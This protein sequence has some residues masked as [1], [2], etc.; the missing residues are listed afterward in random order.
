MLL[1]GSTP[2]G[3]GPW[4]Q[5]K[6]EF[7]QTIYGVLKIPNRGRDSV[8]RETQLAG[9][10]AEPV[11]IDTVE[12]VLGVNAG[13]RHYLGVLPVEGISALEFEIDRD[14]ERP[15]LGFIDTVGGETV[16]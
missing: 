5:Y 11:V 2:L 14:V 8:S 12:A 16:P 13:A 15:H 9:G 3:F 1:R 6:S 10:V 7:P 4:P